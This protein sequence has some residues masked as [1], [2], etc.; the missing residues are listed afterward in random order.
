M[1][2]KMQR[3]ALYLWLMVVNVIANDCPVMPCEDGTYQTQTCT[4]NQSRI[5]TPCPIDKFC[6]VDNAYPCRVCS[7]GF[8]TMLPCVS[9]RNAFC[10][11]CPNLPSNAQFIDNECRWS[12]NEPYVIVNNQCQMTQNAILSINVS[13]V[14]WSFMSIIIV[15]AGASCIVIVSVLLNIFC[16]GTFAYEAI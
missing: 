4:V 16:C 1:S 5:C 15:I 3:L 8:F 11:K 6:L 2:S 13:E 7:V 12:C 14:N 10:Q 9:T